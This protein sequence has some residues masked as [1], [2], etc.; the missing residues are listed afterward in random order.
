MKYA[1]HLLVA[2]AAAAI[3]AGLVLPAQS[4]VAGRAIESHANDGPTE[5]AGPESPVGTGL[6]SANL[7]A[8]MNADGTI[9]RS[10]G[11]DAPNTSRI[12]TGNYQVG[13]K[14]RV[15]ICSF[16]ATVGQVGAGSTSGMADVATRFSSNKAVFVETRDINGV[17]ADR[18]FHLVINC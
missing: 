8:V 12:G 13:F 15:N 1:H 6:G 7:W 18:P 11:G 2:S 16:S 4:Q 9:A 10:D 3:V 5:A 14:R 17:L